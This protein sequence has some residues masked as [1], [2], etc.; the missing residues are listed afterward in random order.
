[1]GSRRLHKEGR[2]LRLYTVGTGPSTILTRNSPL[3]I[4]KIKRGGEG[5]KEKQLLVIPYIANM[6]KII[7][8][9]KKRPS[10][11]KI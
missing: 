11:K 4:K 6:G 8:I 2:K 7:R 1:M 9:K 10:V 3:A 5:R